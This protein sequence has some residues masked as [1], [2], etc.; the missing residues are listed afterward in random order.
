MAYP[1]HDTGAWVV[2]AFNDPQRWVDED[3]RI[4]TEW[5]SARQLAEIMSKVSGKK[6]IP[7]D[8]TMEEFEKTRYAD[9]PGAEDIYLNMLFFV[10]V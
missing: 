2:A 4:V 10:Q 8:L 7:M 3:M 6:V 1:A 5:W 9:W